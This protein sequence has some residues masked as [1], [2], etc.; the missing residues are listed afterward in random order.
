MKQ[1]GCGVLR[2]LLGLFDGRPDSGPSDVVM[3]VPTISN[4]QQKT[5]S[6]IGSYCEFEQLSLV[7]GVTYDHAAPFAFYSS[8]NRPV[9]SSAPE[10]GEERA[11]PGGVRFRG[12][13]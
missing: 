10:H 12:A 4:G 6:H 8:S 11:S 7:L 1:S 13:Y 5:S 9:N 2:D 3:A